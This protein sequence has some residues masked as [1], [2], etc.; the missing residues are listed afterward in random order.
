MGRGLVLISL[1]TLRA[2]ALGAYGAGPGASPAFDAL[3][4]RGV[5]FER[6]YAQIEATL[7]S[8]MTMFTGLYPGEHAVYPPSSILAAEIPTLPEQLAAAGFAT[9]G[10]T[11]GGFVQGG[12][13][14]ARGFAEWS[15]PDYASDA[16]VERTFERGAAWLAAR[17]PGE[18]F[19][20]F[21]HTY[22]IHD[23][24]A[25]PEPFRS[26]SLPQGLPPGAF[27]PTGENLA[28]F[29][30]GKLAVDPAALAAYRALYAASVAH[31]DSVLGRFVDSL[32]RSGL[33][34]ET[35]LVVTS[36]HGEEFLEHGKLAH[37]QIYPESLQVPLLVVPPKSRGGARVASLVGLV[38]LA[39]TLLDWAGVA[40]RAPMS[41]R[42][43]V[44]FLAAS[45]SR[46]T[47]RSAV[48]LPTFDEIYAE[49]EADGGVERTL[50]AD[51]SGRFAQVVH[52]VAEQ[53]NDGFWVSREI[54]FDALGDRLEL[55]AVA[56]HEPRTVAVE[57]DGRSAPPLEL[58]VDW[59][60][61]AIALSGGA[62]QPLAKHS[63]RLATPGCATP[64]SLGL[65]EDLRC[66]SFKLQGVP[67]ER[68]ELYDLAADP[69]A[70]HDL[71][72]FESDLLRALLVR[73][74]TYVHAPRAAP[75]KAALTA[76]Q[77]RQL[78]ALGYL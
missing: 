19:F 29:N 59:R 3:A 71:S 11:E 22:S 75:G 14:F 7:P 37:T 35:T 39:P 36:D 63:V 45:S 34:D 32:E 70:A 62:G 12:Y 4:R 2:D 31:V 56:F 20:L 26:R 74:R 18:R 54:R 33:A 64:A 50:F 13:G 49:R 57:I 47:A 17:K 52:G 24:Y 21:L 9:A 1:D 66:L 10:H 44:P 48:S 72:S 5:L 23:P 51:G 40:P 41:G 15:D 77:E 55:R 27:E 67:L 25:P 76:E 28:A 6:A 65:G 42:S 78:R 43:L 58:G 30:R 8:H 69:R 38:D 16:D 73:L 53:E 60:P 46:A 61:F 68:I